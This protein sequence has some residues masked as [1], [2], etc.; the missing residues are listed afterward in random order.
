MQ[1]TGQWGLWKFNSRRVLP[2]I[3][4]YPDSWPGIPLL[5]P[6][7]RISENVKIWSIYALS[8]SSHKR[9]KTYTRYRYTR[10]QSSVVGMAFFVWEDNASSS[11]QGYKMKENVDAFPTGRSGIEPMMTTLHGKHASKWPKLMIH[12]SFLSH[13]SIWIQ[14]QT[15][16]WFLYTY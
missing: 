4:S 5:L 2:P 11:G 7:S 10:L 16:S 3:A 14:C 9:S 12:L 15:I 1:V 6:R 8:R 13:L